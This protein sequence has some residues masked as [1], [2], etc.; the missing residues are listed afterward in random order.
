MLVVDGNIA[1]TGGVGI[2]DEW[3]GAARGPDE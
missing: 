3:L 2:G 1:F